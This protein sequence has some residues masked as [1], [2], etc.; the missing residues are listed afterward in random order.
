MEKNKKR[1][2]RILFISSFGDLK[3]GG[4]RSLLLLLKY[5]NKQKFIP[6]VIVPEKE[7]V[8]MELEKMGIEVIILSFPRIR[9]INTFKVLAAF[10]KLKSIVKAKEIDLIHADSPRETAYAGIVRFFLKVRVILHLR[11]SDKI[12]WIDK[13]VYQLTDRMIAV[14]RSLT[15]RFKGIDKKNKISVVYNAVDLNEFKP[16]AYKQDNENKALRIGYFGRIVKRK[17]IDVLIKAFNYLDGEISLLIMGSGEDQYLEEL[18]KMAET[19]KRIEFRPYQQN[20][21]DEIN[22]VDIVVLPSVQGEGLSRIII[23]AMAMG[24]IAIA[25]NHPE[26]LEALGCDLERFVFENNDEKD[27]AR[28]ITKIRNNKGLQDS[29]RLVA[30]KRAE[31]FFDARKNTVLIENIYYSILGKK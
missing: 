7:E 23:E 16:L 9:S 13:I 10:F 27:L 14:S 29:I 6:I 3:G 19:D 18:K 4:Q 8:A 26:N 20:I 1:P 5:L 17:G 30:R 22:L 31:H 2:Y 21:H 11:V 15:S 25:S 24:K 12:S 28:I